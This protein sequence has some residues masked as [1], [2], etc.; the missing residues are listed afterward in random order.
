[1]IRDSA[2]LALQRI[3][4]TALFLLSCFPSRGLYFLLHSPQSDRYYHT[5]QPVFDAPTNPRPKWKA[6]KQPL[7]MRLTRIPR[8]VKQT[9]SVPSETSVL[10]AVLTPDLT[11][12]RFPRPESESCSPQTLSSA[13]PPGR[14]PPAAL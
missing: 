6:A 9:P 13:R 12:E 5:S 11:I 10:I 14:A 8:T 2:R 3:L 7:P 4:L 1:M